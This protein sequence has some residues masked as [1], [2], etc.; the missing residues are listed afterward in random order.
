MFPRLVFNIAAAAV[1]A[2]LAPPAASQGM[3]TPVTAQD[4]GDASPPVKTFDAGAPIMS[5]AYSPSGLLFFAHGDSISA[6]SIS[7]HQIWRRSEPTRLVAASGSAILGYRHDD[8]GGALTRYGIGHGGSSI[9]PTET[10]TPSPIAA[11]TLQRTAFAALGPLDVTGSE[12]RSSRGVF[13][14]SDEIMAVS[15]IDADLGPDLEDGA[16][17]VS[18]PDGR[19][20]FYPLEAVKAALGF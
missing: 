8:D 4:A 7:G 2:A 10:S 17:V 12:I 20:S 14:T 11:T 19:V 18:G 3:A 1:L 6:Y 5:I 9:L 13:M 15:A 16:L